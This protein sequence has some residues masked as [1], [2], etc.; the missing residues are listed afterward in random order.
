MQLEYLGQALH[1]DAASIGELPELGVVFDQATFACGQLLSCA[2]AAVSRLKVA[3]YLVRG[4]G[5][6]LRIGWSVNHGVAKFAAN[7]LCDLA[8]CGDADERMR[9]MACQLLYGGMSLVRLGP[10]GAL[11]A[12]IRGLIKGGGSWWMRGEGKGRDWVEKRFQRRACAKV[13]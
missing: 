1:L 10:R 2:P 12:T 9:R 5:C 13:G 4:L 11:P 6:V 3:S 7:A 8:V